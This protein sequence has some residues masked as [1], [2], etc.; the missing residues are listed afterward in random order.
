MLLEAGKCFKIYQAVMD[1]AI[2]QIDSTREQKS[3]HK[4][5]CLACID[6]VLL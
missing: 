1:T 5:R 4:F 2:F 6:E 3:K